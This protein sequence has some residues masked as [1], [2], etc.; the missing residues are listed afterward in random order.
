[1]VDEKG[2]GGGLWWWTQIKR[3]RIK[4]TQGKEERM[5]YKGIILHEIGVPEG[6]RL[7]THT[8]IN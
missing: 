5:R 2:G 1:M 7:Y 8:N 4:K 3:K 6:V